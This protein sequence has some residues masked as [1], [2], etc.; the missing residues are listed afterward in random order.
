M[1]KLFLERAKE[2]FNPPIHPRTALIGPLVPDPQS[3][4]PEPKQPGDKHRFIVCAQVFGFAVF[5]NGIEQMA[6][7]GDAR[8]VEQ[9]MQ[10]KVRPRT[11]LH[12]AE[13]VVE[14]AARIL[15]AG[16]VHRPDPV[17]WHGFGFAVFEFLPQR[18]TGS[19]LEF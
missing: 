18:V 5:L 17:D 10:T 11:M 13:D 14:L 6:E 16:K 8:L 15:L 19:G 7:E 1:P 4:K 12:Q 9:A 3:P 2:P